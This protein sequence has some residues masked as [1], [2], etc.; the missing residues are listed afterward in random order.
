MIEVGFAAGQIDSRGERGSA[1]QVV[2]RQRRVLFAG[3]FLGAGAQ[4]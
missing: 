2:V 3:E 4:E 1:G